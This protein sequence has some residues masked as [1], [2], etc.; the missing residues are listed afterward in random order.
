M[1]R[2]GRGSWDAGDLL[3]V[4]DRPTHLDSAFPIG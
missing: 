1:G 4:V 2:F 3:Q